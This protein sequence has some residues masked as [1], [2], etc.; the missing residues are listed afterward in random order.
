MSVGLKQRKT[1]SPSSW[2][3]SHLVP[4]STVPTRRGQASTSV[5]SGPHL[6][7]GA[8]SSGLSTFYFLF[9]ISARPRPA[10]R[11][12]QPTHTTLRFRPEESIAKYS[13]LD[14]ERPHSPCNGSS[15]QSSLWRPRFQAEVRRI[16]RAQAE[17]GRPSGSLLGGASSQRKD[18][19]GAQT[20]VQS[21]SSLSLLRSAL[22][23]WQNHLAPWV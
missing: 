7:S 6:I 14:L 2:L 1:G 3:K 20:P 22:V 23:E 13:S 17:P 12:L 11:L 5:L 15:V 18:S 16:G 4:F 8:S 10:R 21:S 19:E 9:P